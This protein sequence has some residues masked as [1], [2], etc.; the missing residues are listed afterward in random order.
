MG[1]DRAGPGH[2]WAGTIFRDTTLNNSNMAYIFDV[3]AA[4]PKWSQ[5]MGLTKLGRKI[6]LH[7]AKRPFFGSSERVAA[8]TTGIW[9]GRISIDK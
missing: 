1:Q 4:P 3:L 8:G 6:Y 5:A 9:G 2:V 7:F